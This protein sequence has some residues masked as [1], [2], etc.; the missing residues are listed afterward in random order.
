MRAKDIMSTELISIRLDAT[1]DQAIEIMLERRISGLPVVDSQHHL[2]GIVTEG[3]F[4]RRKE[5]GTGHHRPRWLEFLIGPGRIAD[6]YARSHGRRVVE[7]MSEEVVTASKNATIEQIVE[8]MIHHGIKRVPIVQDSIP[9]GIVSRAD[10]LRVLRTALLVQWPDPIRED[11]DILSDVRAEFDGVKCL[12]KA[13][14]EVSV[15]DGQVELRGSISDE[16][17]RAAVRVAVENVRGVRG[18]KDHLIWIEPLVG[19]FSLSQED[20]E[21]ARTAKLASAP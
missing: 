21:A 5:L 19:I 17:E 14:I 3:D 11:A 12:P 6:E 2:V 4:L 10:V 13:L 8:T 9:I 1:I 20:Q 7:V 16:R 15:C 18:I